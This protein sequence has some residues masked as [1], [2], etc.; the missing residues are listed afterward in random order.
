MTLPA[1]F[2]IPISHASN[3][4]HLDPGEFDDLTRFCL[5]IEE[6]DHVVLGQRDLDGQVQIPN[7]KEVGKHDS[8]RVKSSIKGMFLY[9][10]ICL[11]INLH[12]VHCT[13]IISCS[14]Y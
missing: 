12:T 14:S 2:L 7:F 13:T 10:Y 8:T 3:R 11:A 5:L 9:V 6:V 1:L 4:Q